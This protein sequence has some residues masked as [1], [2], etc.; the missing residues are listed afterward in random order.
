MGHKPKF[1][2]LQDKVFY[3]HARVMERVAI[4]RAVLEL[5]F[6]H[7]QQQHRCPMRPLLIAF[8]QAVEQPIVLAL[9]LFRGDQESPGLLVIR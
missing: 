1:R 7:G 2:N 3:R 9:M 5:Q 6:R 8:D 4:R